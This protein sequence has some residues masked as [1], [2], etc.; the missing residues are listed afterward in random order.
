MDKRYTPLP[1]AQQL[2]LRRQ[3]VQDLLD[4]PQWT[5]RES[6]RHLRST[7]RLTS[8]ELARLAG[9][10]H[11]ALQDIEQGRSPGTVQTMNRIL[12][13]LGLRLGVV[14]APVEPVAPDDGGGPVA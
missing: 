12:G 1:L 9:I 3:A 7:L 10:S 11:R 13:V 5:L 2:L 4:H 14:R 8:A 6:I